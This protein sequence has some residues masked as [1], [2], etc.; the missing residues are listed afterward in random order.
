MRGC[1]A[2]ATA[3]ALLPLAACE[4]QP[5]TDDTP[6]ENAS[7]GNEAA[8]RTPILPVARKMDREALLL[9]VNRAA[10]AAAAGVD[11]A[12]AQGD[13]DGS[14][15][16][17]AI[18]A[19]CDFTLPADAEATGESGTPRSPPRPKSVPAAAPPRGAAPAEEAGPSLTVDYDPE[20]ERLRFRAIPDF[21]L[22]AAPPALV[23]GGPYE[24]VEGFWIARP[25]LLTPACPASRGGQSPPAGP[26]RVVAIAQFFTAGD[27]RTHRRSERAYEWVTRIAPEALP[28][29]NLFDFVLTGRLQAQ[30]GRKVVTCAAEADARPVCLISARIT[31]ARLERPGGEVL[32]RWAGG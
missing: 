10:S 2:A 16:S 12:A 18:R 23:A 15:F 29:P 1:L 26:E 21:S 3:I 20:A 8:E 14:E 28:S 27:A 19:G 4:R 13:L 6:I 32:A 7:A 17:F 31:E 9:A 25:W 24:A 11:D 5:A 30:P 22:D